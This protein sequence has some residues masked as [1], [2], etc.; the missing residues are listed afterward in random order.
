MARDAV[1]STVCSKRP[2]K[3]TVFHANADPLFGGHIRARRRRMAEA[4]L[5]SKPARRDSR[6]VYGDATLRRRGCRRNVL[7]PNQILALT[8][9][10]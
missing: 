7:T 5:G 3:V 10:P 2:A 8:L 4:P 9:Y 6:G 1:I